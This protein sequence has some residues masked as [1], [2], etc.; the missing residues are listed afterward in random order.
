LLIA[1]FSFLSSSLSQ[2][3]YPNAVSA[4]P[5]TPN[6]RGGEDKRLCLSHY[7]KS[8]ENNA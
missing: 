4:L 6:A 3:P 2:T 8:P 1:G 5:Q 7:E